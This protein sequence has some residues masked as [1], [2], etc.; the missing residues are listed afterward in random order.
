MAY[1]KK[2]HLQTNIEAIRITFALEENAGRRESCSNT[3]VLA[4]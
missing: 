2:A 1:N 4:E 3:V